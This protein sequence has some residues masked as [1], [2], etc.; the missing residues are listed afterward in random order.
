M[1]ENFKRQ[2]QKEESRDPICTD[3]VERLRLRVHGPIDA[4]TLVYLPGLHGDW[5]LI[6]P[7][8]REVLPH[9]RF[10]D[11]TYPRSESWNLSDYAQSIEEALT[12][13]G[14]L[15][16]WVIGES[17]GSQVLWELVK[18]GRLR[19]KGIILAGGFVQYPTP[20]FL[21]LARYLCPRVSERMLHPVLR[22]YQ[23]YSFLRFRKDAEALE[24]AREF[25]AR[26]TGADQLAAVRR[27]QL[28][29]ENDPRPVA[30][31]TRI[32]VHHLYGAWD[33]IVPWLTVANWLRDSCPSLR[34]SRRIWH[35]DHAVLVAA[36][37]AS[38]EQVRA[39]MA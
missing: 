21:S 15:E 37:R 1:A 20:K 25:V 7:F 17:F 22:A 26:R 35:S 18:R 23:L 36:A 13:E 24:G 29:A 14:I 11:L 28:I 30:V 2:P 27:L 3:G 5:T 34:G 8:R 38:A 32:P 39:W 33:P 9:V 31:A 19:I 6:G 12:A 16:G 10:V 4:K